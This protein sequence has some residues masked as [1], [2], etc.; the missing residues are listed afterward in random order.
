[1]IRRPAALL[2]LAGL[3]VAVLAGGVLAAVQH[4]IEVRPA[5]AKDG[6]L[7]VLV[8]GSDIGWPTRPGDA[9]RGNADAIHLIAFDTAAR[10][11]TIVDIPRDSLIGG[12]KVNAHLVRGGPP[13]LV[14]QIEGHTGI[15]ITHWVLT[16]FHGLERM[17][18]EL[19]GVEVVV[20]RPMTAT[21]TAVALQ[22]GPQ[23]LGP[24]EALG[25][26]RDR[27]SQPGGDFDRTRNQGRLLRAAHAQIRARDADLRSLTRLTAVLARDTHSSIPRAELLPLAQ[28]AVSIDPADIRQD[29]LAGGF[30]TIGGA[31]IVHLAPGDAFDRIRAG[32]VGP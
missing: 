28:L 7:T 32:V 18:A 12:T 11:A 10:R 22:P 1:V 27:K 30:G 6:L 14:A 23:V 26:T 15:P 9:L 31:S 24:H 25:F 8:I 21:G 29:S 4:R 13:A 5:Y 17:V 16:T 2:A 20:E 3:L 19:G